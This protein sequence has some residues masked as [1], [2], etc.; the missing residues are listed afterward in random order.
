MKAFTLFP[1]LALLLWLLQ[2]VAA[3]AQ[4]EDPLGVIRADEMVDVQTLLSLAEGGDAAGSNRTT[5][6]RMRRKVHLDGCPGNG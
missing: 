3:S 2:A 5:R 4:E 6:Q 1:R